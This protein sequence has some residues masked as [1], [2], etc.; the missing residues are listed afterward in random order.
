M[1]PD[2]SC[3]LVATIKYK[4]KSVNEDRILL[5]LDFVYHESPSGGP[6]G[7]QK[8]ALVF[9]KYRSLVATFKAKK[10]LSER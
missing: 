8:E 2:I 1:F 3:S 4:T 10:R 5:S 9:G 6:R 7:K